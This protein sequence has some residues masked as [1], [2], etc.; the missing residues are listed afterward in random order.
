MTASKDHAYK[1][2]NGLKADLADRLRQL[3]KLNAFIIDVYANASRDVQRDIELYAY[4]HDV[5]IQAL[6]Y[7]HGKDSADGAT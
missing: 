6:I 7:F 1:L 2:A 4:R 3:S 5:N